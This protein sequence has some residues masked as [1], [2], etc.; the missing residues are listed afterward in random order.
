VKSPK[1]LIEDLEDLPEGPRILRLT[2]PL[3]VTTVPAFQSKVRTDPSHNLILDFTAVPYVDSIGMGTLVDVN[4]RHRRDGKS[5]CLVRASDRVRSLL[6]LS[7]VDRFFRFF[8]SLAEAQA[9]LL[10]APR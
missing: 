1:L 9:A 4:I 10:A 2:G 6:K 5:V 8:D 3:T 7:R